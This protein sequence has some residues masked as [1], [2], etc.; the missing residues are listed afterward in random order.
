MSVLLPHN[1]GQAISD[2]QL[3]QARSH[4]AKA[5]QRIDEQLALI[6]NLDVHR[7]D[8]RAADRL[9]AALMWIL[10]LE[11]SSLKS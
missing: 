9:L 8:T 6:A 3:Q 11:T 4:V 5:F 2:L 1:E 10:D 7:Q